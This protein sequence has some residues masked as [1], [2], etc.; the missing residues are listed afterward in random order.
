MKKRNLKMTT[1]IYSLVRAAAAWQISQ[2]TELYCPLI[3]NPGISQRNTLRLGVGLAAS[4]LWHQRWT[5]PRWG[6]ACWS[7]SS[8]L[9]MNTWGHYPLCDKAGVSWCSTK[10]S[11]EHASPGHPTA[12]RPPLYKTVAENGEAV[13][14]SSN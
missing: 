14:S 10:L 7:H 2:E 3:A 11:K 9:K 4:V 8:T 12:P 1:R 6:H 13:T 5:H